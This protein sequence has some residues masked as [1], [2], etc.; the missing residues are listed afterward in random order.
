LTCCSWVEW[1]ALRHG[2]CRDLA[3]FTALVVVGAGLDY[4]WAGWPV[5]AALAAAG[6][7]AFL[8]LPGSRA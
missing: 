1:G 4:T 5:F 8:D 2:T 7:L 3:E 6:L